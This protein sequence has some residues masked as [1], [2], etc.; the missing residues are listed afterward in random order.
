MNNKKVRSFDSLRIHYVDDL[1]IS[2]KLLNELSE[3]IL[4][5]I[6]TEGI[7]GSYS[8][9]SEVSRLTAKAWRA[10]WA[11]GELKR[12]EAQLEV[13]VNEAVERKLQSVLLS[14]KNPVK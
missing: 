13:E 12:L 2:M 6:D 11:L 1:R 3:Q 7:S 14:V 5:K 4:K 9:N 10:S 8:I